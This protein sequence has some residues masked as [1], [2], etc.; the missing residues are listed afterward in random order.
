[1]VAVAAGVYSFFKLF[2]ISFTNY[3]LICLIGDIQRTD[4]LVR[5]ALCNGLSVSAILEHIAKASEGLYRP[6]SFQEHEIHIAQ[7][8][9]RI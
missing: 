7:L 2:N 3:L 6:S 8:L 5:T 9:C 1:M 4:A